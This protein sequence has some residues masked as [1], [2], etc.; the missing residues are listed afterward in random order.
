VH[1][2]KDTFLQ[3][4]VQQLLACVYDLQRGEDNDESKNDEN[5]RRKLC[6]TRFH[7]S[8]LMKGR[9]FL[10]LPL[11][12]PNGQSNA[13]SGILEV[14][15]EE[16]IPSRDILPMTMNWKYH[17]RHLFNIGQPSFFFTISR[18]NED[19]SRSMV[20]RSNAVNGF[21]V[22]WPEMIIDLQKL[23]N[24]D[25]QRPLFFTVYNNAKKDEPLGEL[26]TCVAQILEQA[27]VPVPIFPAPNAE[28]AIGDFTITV[29]ARVGDI[30]TFP[31]VSVFAVRLLSFYLSNVLFLCFS[32]VLQYL[33]VL[34]ASLLFAVDLT[35]SN[36]DQEV[37][38][39]RHHISDD[40][41][42]LNPY[43]RCISI[44]GRI[45]ERFDA[46]KKYQVYG[47]GAKVKNAK[48]GRFSDPTKHCI[49]IAEEADGIDGVLDHYRQFV[50]NAMLSGPTFFAPI[51]REAT[52][53]ALENAGDNSD[54]TNLKYTILTII[55]D[56]NIVDMEDT[57]A[58]IVEASKTPLSI[59][60]IGV[61]SD[62]EADDAPSADF[63]TQM[64]VL[65]SDGQLLTHNGVAAE[66]DIVQFVP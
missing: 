59:I 63:F 51:I 8:N 14:R 3:G 29:G 12:P 46:D 6:E 16:S 43:Q 61:G 18:I 54:G 17:N 42:I 38:G 30:P 55:T 27:A 50:P 4:G 47:F 52:H 58:A 65:D 9:R 23:C 37:M 13:N 25:D 26:Q 64:R 32:L 5:N 62:G 11:A 15:A 66:R 22:K 21:D 41:T 33:K 7:L 31:D 49:R 34:N 40:P 20:Y 57:K 35:G 56:G 19:N 2:F 39:S 44:G 24:V 48:T 28:T 10:S 45:L 53:F 60:I 1:H 36:G